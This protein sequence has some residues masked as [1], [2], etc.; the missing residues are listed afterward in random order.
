MR[1]N[2]LWE[3]K[4]RIL[5]ILVAY[6]LSVGALWAFLPPRPRISITL[7][8]PGYA[9][10]IS[11]DGRTLVTESK[12]PSENPS[13]T[14]RVWD[15]RT[16]RLNA[17]LPEISGPIWEVIVSPDGS[18]VAAI[19]GTKLEGEGRL[20][21]LH[22]YEVA[23]GQE[24]N[25]FLL[26]DAEGFHGGHACFSPDGS[27]L[28]FATDVQRVRTVTLWDV[29][30]R[31]VR[32]VLQGQQE[33]LAFSPDGWTLATVT[34]AS[35]TLVKVWDVMTG[36]ERL[37]LDHPRI[38]YKEEMELTFIIPHL[39]FSIDGATLGMIG[40]IS[41]T[42]RGRFVEEVE[43]GLKGDYEERSPSH[44]IRRW[45]MVTGRVQAERLSSY[46]HSTAPTDIPWESVYILEQDQGEEWEHLLDPLTGSERFRV[47]VQGLPD[48]AQC[49]IWLGPVY[50]IRPAPNDEFVLVQQSSGSHLSSG[51]RDWLSKLIPW[52]KWAKRSTRWSSA[53]YDLRNGRHVVT[54]P[55]QS[56]GCFSRD[57]Q[58]L[59]TLSN[60]DKTVYIWDLPPNTPWLTILGW[61]AL[62]AGLLIMVER[63]RLRQACS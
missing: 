13:S 48:Y 6:G 37:T 15:L 31:Q 45:D 54:L 1:L 7:P 46:V 23:T 14:L 44:L 34:S 56:F 16:G 62:P 29:P 63:W 12:G 10:A 60:E 43:R 28:A 49:D 35:D 27:T 3:K 51:W 40:F 57:G 22:V 42:D 36:R 52:W 41:L 33:P 8:E 55:D 5:A 20:P 21:I 2:P 11:R 25:R 4:N 30:T 32:T 61:A 59:A 19:V 50:G 18:L 58:A 53:L 17:E 38:D 39:A 24:T 26:R 9:V 47:A